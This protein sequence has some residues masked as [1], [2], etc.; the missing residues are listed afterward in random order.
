MPAYSLSTP[1]SINTAWPKIKIADEPTNQKKVDTGEAIHKSGRPI[2][3]SAVYRDFWVIMWSPT[4]IGSGANLLMAAKPPA[5]KARAIRRRGFVILWILLGLGRR[6]VGNEKKSKDIQSVDGK[7]GDDDEVVTR[8]VAGIIGHTLCHSISISTPSCLMR[9]LRPSRTQTTYRSRL[10]HVFGS[11]ELSVIKPY[12][13][14]RI[15]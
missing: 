13:R 2:T 7:N 5:R 14:I 1:G 8:V 11:G 12:G 15:N 6:E 4:C 9:L 10:I 3:K